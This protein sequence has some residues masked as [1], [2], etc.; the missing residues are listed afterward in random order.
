MKF[1]LKEIFRMPERRKSL[2]ITTTLH[3]KI[4]TEIGEQELEVNYHE[5]F[6]IV[7]R[8]MD[9]NARIWC[10]LTCE[11]IVKNFTKLIKEI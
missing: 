10:D 8:N 11:D 9:K 7:F 2:I 5:L 3:N 4:I 1:K 6:N